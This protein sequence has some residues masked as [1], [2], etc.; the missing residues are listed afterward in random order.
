MPTVLLEVC[1][2]RI[3]GDDVAVAV[4]DFVP[5][6]LLLWVGLAVDVFEGGEDRVKE[7]DEVDVFVP[8][9]LRVGLTVMRPV[10]VPLPVLV[11]HGLALDDFD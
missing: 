3:L 11:E 10:P 9:L 4:P 1:V 6:L 5:S 7:D 8:G 2:T